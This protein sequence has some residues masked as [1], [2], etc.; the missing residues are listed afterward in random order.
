MR[1][2][3]LIGG[4]SL[5][6]ILAN[7]KLVSTARLPRKPFFVYMCGSF[8]DDDLSRNLCK[9]LDP[10]L[11]LYS[12]LIMFSSHVLSKDGSKAVISMEIVVLHLLL[13]SPSVC[14]K[15]LL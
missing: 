13:V 14:F 6:E 3:R 8:A 4:E 7:E 12:K 11:Q 10:K 1:N 2:R 15:F 5:S 9:D